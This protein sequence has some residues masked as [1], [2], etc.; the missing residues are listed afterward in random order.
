MLPPQW[1]TRS[2]W[3]DPGATPVHSPKVRIGTRALSASAAALWVSGRR[4]PSRLS[5]PSSRSTVAAL[6]R[7]SRARVGGSK[8]IS[9][10]RSSAP[11][12]SL[13]NGASRLP[14]GRS[15][16]SQATRSAPTTSGPYRAGRPRRF[17]AGRTGSRPKSRTAA[18][19]W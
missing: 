17:A 10:W 16:A 1:A 8:A 7:S 15:A 6:S 3:T 5:G 11:T 18:L 14:Q 13:R 9:P 19:R 4:R 2:A 12:S